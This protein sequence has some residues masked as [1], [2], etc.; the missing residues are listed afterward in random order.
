VADPE[1]GPGAPGQPEVRQAML[2]R[3]QAGRIAMT[4]VTEL[5]AGFRRAGR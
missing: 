2:P 4:I 5:E 3:L 1:A